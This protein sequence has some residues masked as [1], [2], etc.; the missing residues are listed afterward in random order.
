MKTGIYSLLS[1]SAQSGHKLLALLID[2]DNF[3]ADEATLSAAGSEADL[4]F[5]GGSLLSKGDLEKTIAILKSRCAVPVV[6][7]PGSIAQ[8]SPA[9]DAIL[10]LS[11]ISGRNAEFLIGQHVIAAPALRASSLEIMPTGYMLVDSGRQTT[12][13][14][15]SGTTPIPH[16]KDD[17]AMCTAL[18]GE[19][20]G[21]RIIYLDGGS[22]ALHPVS[23]S[24]VRCVKKNISVPLIVGGGIRDASTAQKLCQAGADVIVVG[25]AIQENPALL[26][27]LAAAIHAIPLLQ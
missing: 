4:I 10:N 11:L 16:D 20:L 23:E 19:M 8:V 15:I 2:P 26:K 7:F 5:V 14:Y 25:N 6:L 18:A 12:A 24:M 21:L 1:N 9:A 3:Q 22:G 27:K 13:S 17:I